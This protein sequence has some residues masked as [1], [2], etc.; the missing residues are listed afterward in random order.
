MDKQALKAFVCEL[1]ADSDVRTDQC[2][3]VRVFWNGRNATITTRN[4]NWIEVWV[5]LRNES[6]A[7]DLI[8]DPWIVDK[9]LNERDA[10]EKLAKWLKR[11]VSADW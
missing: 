1:L 3:D 8:P 9:A 7:P 2:D 5:M 10:A 11:V 6:D 4:E